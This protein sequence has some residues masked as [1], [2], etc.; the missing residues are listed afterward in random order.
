VGFD[1]TRLE[2][3]FAVLAG[4]V[5]RGELPSA[6]LAVAGP[7]GL[8][9]A[10]AY[11]P[12]PGGP[13]TTAHRYRIASV[14]KPILATALLQLVEEGRLSLDEP[15]R[16]RIPEFS[17]P[18]PLAGGPG[19]EII[20]AWHLLTHTAGLV[21][22][23]WVASG[24]PSAA[25]ILATQCST[26]L[27]FVPGTAYQYASDSFFVLGELLVRAGGH[28]SVRAALAERIFGPLGMTATG[29][30]PVLPGHPSA[31]SHVVGRSDAEAAIF[32]AWMSTLD[33]PGGGLS[34][35]AADL[36]AFGRAMLLGGRLD[37]VRIL[38]HPFVELMTREQTG[39]VLEAGDPPRPPTYGLGWAK[40]T[41]DGSM[42]GSP[43]QFDHMGAS[44]SRLWVDPGFGL[45]I[46]LLAD[47]W[48]VDKRLS[49]EVISAVYGA[50]DAV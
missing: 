26:P 25:A 37:G 38:G 39:R 31:V 47:R 50:L 7:G 22:L 32:D 19:G 48:G 3:P 35:S 9:R 14:T 13:A 20:T 5:A 36:V 49:N 15:V 45:V 8:V 1:A 24:L 43:G 16:T 33:Q 2:R 30:D 18:G 23:D 12:E 40:S 21:D 17:P 11:G 29:F 6:V 4:Q 42:P 27:A 34:S 46:V 10:E 44:G 28:A 41:L